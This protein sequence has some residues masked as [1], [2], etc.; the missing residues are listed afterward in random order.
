MKGREGMHSRTIHAVWRTG[1]V[2]YGS[3][4]MNCESRTRI[5]VCSGSP[6]S[7]KIENYVLCN[8]SL[9][10]VSAKNESELPECQ[11]ADVRIGVGLRWMDQFRMNQKDGESQWTQFQQKRYLYSL[12]SNCIAYAEDDSSGD[13]CG[14]KFSVSQTK[15]EL[16]TFGLGQRR[17]R[18]RWPVCN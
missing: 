14:A 11:L 15:I 7:G 1:W 2:S 9:A 4:K 16:N 12:F 5:Y 3:H 6:K 8:G 13:C 18:S 10:C 17:R